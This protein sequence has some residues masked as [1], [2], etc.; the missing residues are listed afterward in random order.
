MVAIHRPILGG[1]PWIDYYRRHILK[2]D[3][4]I[5]D[6]GMSGISCNFTY[7]GDNTSRYQTLIEFLN[8]K[9]KD[10]HFTFRC[11]LV[12]GMALTTLTPFLFEFSYSID[13]GISNLYDLMIKSTHHITAYS[14]CCYEV[15]L[16][17][18]A[19][20]FMGLM[21]NLLCERN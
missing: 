10:I 2:I 11:H 1:Y 14:S 4:R 21:Q 5:F 19:H 13:D 3:N 16:A 15:V 18:Y 12:F 8:Q 6:K 20:C 9:P 7:R 17:A